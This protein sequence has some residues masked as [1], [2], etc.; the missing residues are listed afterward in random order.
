[1]VSGFIG[2]LTYAKDG[3]IKVWSSGG[4]LIWGYKAPGEINDACWFIGD[5][6]ALATQNGLLFCNVITQEGQS[7][8]GLNFEISS[9]VHVN[10]NSLAFISKHICPQ[11][12]ESLVYWL[13]VFNGA[14]QS[15]MDLVKKSVIIALLNGLTAWDSYV[16]KMITQVRFLLIK[17]E[18]CVIQ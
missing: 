2:F 8:Q 9:V 12:D 13:H 3:R 4:D 11:Q 10:N 16:S 18:A 14:L 17:K 5:C 7:L 1:M 15:N 6:V